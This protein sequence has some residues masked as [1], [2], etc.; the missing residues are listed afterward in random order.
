MPFSIR[1]FRR[2][3]LTYFSGF[4][5]LIALLVLSSGPA[6]AEWEVVDKNDEGTTY[7][8]PDT[9]RRNGGLVKVWTLHDYKTVRT[10]SGN[11]FWSVKGQEEYDCEEQRY[12][13]LA[14]TGFSG[15]RGSG[16]AVSSNST[17]GTWQPV[18]SE[19]VGHVLWTVACA[20]K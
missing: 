9:I 17:E 18:A 4:M 15:N 2:F 7:I 6:Y 20:K 10:S 12:R 11:S 14:W 13:V 1:P 5:A 8:D 16:K 3:P 19:S